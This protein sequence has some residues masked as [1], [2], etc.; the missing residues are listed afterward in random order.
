MDRGIEWPGPV[1]LPIV[2]MP[3]LRDGRARW[4]AHA[5]FENPEGIDP[6]LPPRESIE[7]R[8]LIFY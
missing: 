6:K 2:S 8:T 1:K 3:L 7:V 5:S 4:T